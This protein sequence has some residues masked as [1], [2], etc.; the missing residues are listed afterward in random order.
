VPFKIKGIR[1]DEDRAF[2]LCLSARLGIRHAYGDGV[3][4]LAPQSDLSEVAPPA[5]GARVPFSKPLMLDKTVSPPAITAQPQ[6]QITRR[7]M[8]ELA[9][10]L[11]GTVMRGGGGGE[12]ANGRSGK[13]TMSAEARRRIA[14]AARARWAKIKAAKGQ[15][16]PASTSN[17]NAP[18]KRMMSPAA[19]RKIA[20]AARA[21]WAKCERRRRRHSRY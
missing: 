13:R 19:R 14:E 9:Q 11:N 18:K 5:S 12:A 21:R 16:A 1:T 15:S 4:Y 7:L 17:Q 3:V 10:I 20:A 2:V 6:S 8:N